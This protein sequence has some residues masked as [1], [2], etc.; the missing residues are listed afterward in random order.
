MEN[1][2]MT[3]EIKKELAQECPACEAEKTIVEKIVS[4]SV[5]NKKFKTKTLAC[6]K[7]GHFAL[8]P[9]IRNEMDEWGRGL[10][11]NIVEPQPIFSEATQ[12]FAV[13]MASQYGL[14]K[15]PFYRLL[16][17]FYMNHV[18]DRI[19]FIQIKKYM[20]SHDSQVFLFEGKKTKVS[21]PIRY[22]MFKKLRAFSEILNI[23]KAKL[24]EEAVIFGLVLLANKNSNFEVLKNIAEDLQQY[25]EDLAQAA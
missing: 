4:I 24:I 13:E 21:V 22:L 9:E 5:G 6:K 7:C 11:K 18:M 19:D 15:V 20:D 1:S 25:I 16:T 23:P 2:F 10:T 3:K 17:V 8:T 12:R 14:K